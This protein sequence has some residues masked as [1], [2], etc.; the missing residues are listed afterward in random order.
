[1]TNMTNGTYICIIK[2][3]MN[4]VPN[5]PNPESSLIF[6][7]HMVIVSY[8]MV[9]NTLLLIALWRITGVFV[10]VHSLHITLCLVDM[11][12]ATLLAL[13]Y[14]IPS[15][16]VIKVLEH[17]TCNIVKKT[18]ITVSRTMIISEP[19]F[20]LLVVISRY[21]V[22]T[23]RL[24][25]SSRH[26]INTK[27]FVAVLVI[28]SF[29]L[30]L[31]FAFCNIYAT[32]TE[33]D[34]MIITIFY[35][36]F[37]LACTIGTIVLNVKMLQFI[38]KHQQTSSAINNNKKKR[39]TAHNREAARTLF[40]IASVAML[41]ALPLSVIQLTIIVEFIKGRYDT[42]Q[43]VVTYVGWVSSPFILNMGLN[44]NIYI[45][46]NRDIRKFFRLKL[47]ILTC[48]LLQ[49]NRKRRDTL[50]LQQGKLNASLTT[51]LSEAT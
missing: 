47:K 22:V 25:P 39:D 48:N 18:W 43:V 24:S 2:H 17:A 8:V 40:I 44:A 12:T 4:L 6:W 9:T 31:V 27:M 42:A 36:G 1:M 51:V 11:A 46:R 5:S 32:R 34:N 30:C 19:L 16:D 20:F 15:L 3:A 26:F 13:N 10:A 37:L 28:S 14:V 41:C 50:E 23:S 33:L 29:S 49:R 35:L 38:R 45:Y 7:I 21:S